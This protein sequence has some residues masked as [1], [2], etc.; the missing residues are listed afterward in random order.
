M[1]YDILCFSILTFQPKIGS[2]LTNGKKFALLVKSVFTSK[3]VKQF[4]RFL[5]VYRYT[6]LQPYL[7]MQ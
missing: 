7:G 6:N 3:P 4:Y 1:N 5:L 2:I